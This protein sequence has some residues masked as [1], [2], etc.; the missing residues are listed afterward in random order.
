MGDAGVEDAPENMDFICQ[1][2]QPIVEVRV[3][4]LLLGHVD[5]LPHVLRQA[6]VGFVLVGQVHGALL[7][8]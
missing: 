8:G 6:V 7:R 5:G 4:A 2:R 3:L 1:V